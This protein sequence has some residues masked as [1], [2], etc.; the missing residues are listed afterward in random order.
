MLSK[1]LFKHATLLRQPQLAL[2]STA[3]AKPSKA[4][5]KQAKK[6]TVDAETVDTPKKVD[7]VKV[8]H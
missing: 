3:A 2:F 4:N 1:L 5:K 8:V 6:V 7:D